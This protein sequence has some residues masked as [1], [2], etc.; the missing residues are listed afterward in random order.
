VVKYLPNGECLIEPLHP[1]Y[2]IGEKYAFSFAGMQK[3]VDVF[4][5]I[6]AVI[7]VNDI[8]GQEI[9]VKPH[10]WQTLSESYNPASISCFVQS[11]RKG[12]PVLLNVEEEG[13][14]P[15]I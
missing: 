1:F 12:R 3:T 10:L 9:R 8:F 11:F 6:E 4:G 14:Q 7:K 5:R 2:R 13:G 15:N